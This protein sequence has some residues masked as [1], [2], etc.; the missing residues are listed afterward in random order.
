[1]GVLG[2]E[3][4][5]ARAAVGDDVVDLGGRQPMRDRHERGVELGD[6]RLTD[7]PLDPVLR[8]DR[9]AVACADLAARAQHIG[10]AV[11]REVP[12]GTGQRARAL[13]QRARAG[14]V[15]GPV[16]DAAAACGLGRRAH[17]DSVLRTLRLSSS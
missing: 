15:L 10:Q 13:A 7:E 3:H 1:V 11:G 12:L 16:L 14:R 5:C 6:R 4:E 9:D 8:A 17:G 2:V